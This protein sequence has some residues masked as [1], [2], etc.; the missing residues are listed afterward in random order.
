[1][2]KL[3]NE[4]L[5]CLKGIGNLIQDRDQ[6]KKVIE[7]IEELEAMIRVRDLPGEAEYSSLQ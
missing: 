7:N 3:I 5:A 2:N 4:K 1:M 6:A